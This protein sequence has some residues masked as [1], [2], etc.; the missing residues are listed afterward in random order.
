MDSSSYWNKVLSARLTRRRVIATT[1]GA[2]GAAAFLAACGGDED[3][4]D[5]RG[6]DT[7]GLLAQIVDETNQ[8]KTGGTFRVPGLEPPH[9]DGKAQGHVQQLLYN[10]IAY[11][12]LIRNKPGVGEPSTFTEVLP[13][14]ATS[15]EF[16]GD[17][18][19]LTFKLR[20]GVKFHNRPPVNGRLF[21]SE[22][23]VKTW[24]FFTARG[25][26]NNA[27]ASANA[28]N[29]EA[30]I[31]AMEAPDARTVVVKLAYPAAFILQRFANMFAGELGAIYPRE[32][33]TTFDPARDQIGTGPFELEEFTPS[34]RVVHKRFQDYWDQ[35]HGF[36][37]RIEVPLLL[38]PPAQLAQL[39]NGTLSTMSLAPDLVLQSK[40]DR[41]DLAL[42]QWLNASM[43]PGIGGWRFGWL[44]ID[45]KRSP[46]LDERVRQAIS[47]S[48][49]RKTHLDTLLNVSNFQAAGL[50]VRGY[51]NSCQG[52]GVPD[53]WLDPEDTS[54]FGKT[55]RFYEYNVDEARKL[56]QAAQADYGGPFPKITSRFNA[57]TYGPQYEQEH[58]VLD[59]FARE[60]GLDIE[61]KGI[62]YSLEWIP[63][64]A[65]QRGDFGGTVSGGGALTSEHPI[66]Y[67]LYRYFS[68]T[69]GTSG[70]IYGGSFKPEPIIDNLI[71]R[72]RG[73]F[74]TKKLIETVHE[75]QRI[76]AEK[77][78]YVAPPGRAETISAAWPA[79]RNFRTFLGDTRYVSQV[80]PGIGNYWYDDTKPHG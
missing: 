80:V 2:G 34:V 66:D 29:P 6:Q 24:Q 63:D 68:R 59:Q 42:Y 23:V 61:T 37:G 5:T 21:D 64:F 12:A 31:L 45:G 13:E 15:W 19:Q 44:P 47:M 38:D 60:I 51:W 77:A 40:R 1:L 7:S 25:N 75:L 32:S 69:G 65:T 57:A 8:A 49:D 53:V 62:N 72:G 35:N 27:T 16:S 43:T 56:L 22:D 26:P 36:L 74:D 78:Y 18:L 70:M 11:E 48:I 9:F 10:S 17:R 52:S 50:P 20:E 79:I 58:Q 41:P 67:Y 76:L 33:G 28:L 3:K 4:G 14:L 30:P 55:A 46:F 54:K 39:H 71:E 73:E